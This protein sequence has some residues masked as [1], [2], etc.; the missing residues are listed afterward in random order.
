MSYFGTTRDKVSGLLSGGNLSSSVIDRFEVIEQRKDILLNVGFQV[1]D[2]L[3]LAPG[4]RRIRFDN[5]FSSFTFV[6]PA[7]GGEWTVP[8][9]TS[10]IVLGVDWAANLSGKVNNHRDEFVLFDDRETI[11]YYGEPRY[12]VNWRALFAFQPLRRVGAAVGYEGSVTI[13]QGILRN[14]HGVTLQAEF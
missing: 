9:N 6:G 13:F 10:S 12:L 14:S 2:H 3:S 4:I 8:W 7:L 1:W 11:S 5:T